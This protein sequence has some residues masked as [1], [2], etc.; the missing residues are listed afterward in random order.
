MAILL[1]VGALLMISAYGFAVW[2]VDPPTVNRPVVS[3]PPVVEEA[4]VEGADEDQEKIIAALPVPRARED[5]IY[6]ILVAGEDDGFG[7]ND[8]IMVVVVNATAG[9]IDVLSIP[10][11]TMVNVPWGLKKINSIQHMHRY[12]PE[13]FDHYIYAL[14]AQ[15]EKLVGFPMDHWVTVDLDGFIDLVDAVGGVEFDVPRRMSYHDPFQDLRIDLAPG[16]QRLNGYQ[17]MQ[18]VRYR[19]YV[20]GDIA[21]IAVQQDF[22][23]ALS[24]QL[25]RARNILAVDDLIRAFRDNVDT[26]LTLRNLAY[27]AME[28]LQMESENI[29]F[30]AVDASIANIGDNVH[31]ISYVSLFVEPWL[32]LINTHL[33][34]HPWEIQAEDLEILTR[35]RATGEFFT[36]NGAPFSNNWI[37]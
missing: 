25:L 15:V 2:F 7:G 1:A 32:E 36:T 5:R 12:L 26:S 17:A 14:A 34:P 11:D 3:A 33:N 30:H 27:L 31:G 16:V 22:M 37:R 21:R 6:T 8:V 23:S 10:R 29:N 13:T 18:L 28:F 4:A 35:D 19:G 9:S 24:G 20:E